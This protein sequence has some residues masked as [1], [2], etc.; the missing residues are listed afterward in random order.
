MIRRPPRSTRTDTLFPYTTLFRSDDLVQAD[1]VAGG[2]AVAPAIQAGAVRRRE[3]V[4]ATRGQYR[5]EHGHALPVRDRDRLAHG[6]GHPD[7]RE[8]LVAAQFGEDDR[9]LRIADVRAEFLL[10]VGR[11]LGRGESAGHHVADQ[12]YRDLAVGAD[13]NRD[14]E[15]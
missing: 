2:S 5:V 12:R 6:P 14:A 10:D 8:V 9:D 4:D 7:P 13:R 1:G 3:L 15:F 11:D